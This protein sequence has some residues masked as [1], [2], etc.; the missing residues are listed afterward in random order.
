MAIVDR[1]V[2]PGLA[3]KIR[4]WLEVGSAPKWS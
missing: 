2:G 3:S 4:P 1:H